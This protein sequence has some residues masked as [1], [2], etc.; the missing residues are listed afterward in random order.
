MKIN[1]I[2]IYSIAAAAISL[3]CDAI[4]TFTDRAAW[5]SALGSWADLDLSSQLPA[6][7]TLL[8]GGSLSL[9]FG[10][11][12]SFD[13]VLKGSQVPESWASWSNGNA[14]RVLETAENVTKVSGTFSAT[15]SAFGIEMQPDFPHPFLMSLTLSD[16]SIISELVDGD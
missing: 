5:E 10:Q 13:K 6:G 3:E 12:V 9:P 14:P 11:T 15:I 7:G 1:A 8:A 16:G 2:L 4:S